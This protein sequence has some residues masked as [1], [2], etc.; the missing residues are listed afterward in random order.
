[1]DI[2]V[3][4]RMKPIFL[5]YFKSLGYN[6]IKVLNNNIL[7]SEI[8]SHPDIFACRVKEKIIA[9]SN[10][11]TDKKI[12]DC[13]FG[14]N[15]ENLYPN[16][17]KYNVC[18]TNKYAI[19]LEKYIS[20]R[21]KK[22]IK[23]NKLEVIN[24]NQGYTKCSLIALNDEN[25]ITSDIGIKVKLEERGFNVLYVHNENIKLLD[26]NGSYSNMT[27]FIG[28]ATCVI[29]NKFILFGDRDKLKEK[30]ILEE[31]L[32]KNGYTFI[33]FKGEDIIDYGSVVLIN[34]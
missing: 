20:D 2:L 32:I 10:I 21:L 13:V 6:V 24:V 31:F 1:M 30:A 7:Y 3:D 14:E 4:F 15:V 29:D 12:T 34:N 11:M 25:Y 28:G 17:I 9:S 22:E 27:G 23:K 18:I 19:C 26:E 16:D 33:D 5:E 8:S